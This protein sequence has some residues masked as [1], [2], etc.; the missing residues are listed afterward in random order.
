MFVFAISKYM[1]SPN[2]N[3]VSLQLSNLSNN[4]INDNSIQKLNITNYRYDM[5][6]TDF[7]TQPS[8]VSNNDQ[9]LGT[10]ARVFCCGDPLNVKSLLGRPGGAVKIVTNAIGAHTIER[11]DG[12]DEVGENKSLSTIM[13]SPNRF[14][15]KTKV[16]NLSDNHLDKIGGLIGDGNGD[17]C[18]EAL[19]EDEHTVRKMPGTS[20]RSQNDLIQFV[21]T[22]HGI[23]VISDKEYVV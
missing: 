13:L 5:D 12:D 6:E 15:D 19:S 22:S 11:D 4:L 17:S 2:Q 9:R 16:E 14:V 21:F 8:F 7:S 20:A 18:F 23:R 1:L 3:T 10:A